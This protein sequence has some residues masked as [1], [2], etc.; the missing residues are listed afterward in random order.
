MFHKI[1]GFISNAFIKTINNKKRIKKTRSR[2][3]PLSLRSKLS[4]HRR[5]RR[6]TSYFRS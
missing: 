2:P 6:T 5:S 3:R 1:G 4:N